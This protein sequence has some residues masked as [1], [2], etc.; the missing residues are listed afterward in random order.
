[1]VNISLILQSVTSLFISFQNHTNLGLLLNC[2][3]STK[4]CPL[5][6]KPFDQQNQEKAE[7]HTRK[8]IDAALCTQYHSSNYSPLSSEPEKEGK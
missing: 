4:F 1:M 6:R 7:F 3:L 8:L 2:E 5:L